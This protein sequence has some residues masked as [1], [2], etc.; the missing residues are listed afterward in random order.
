MRKGLRG[1]LVMGAAAAISLGVSSFDAEAASIA[2]AKVKVNYNTQQLQITGTTDTKFYLATSTVSINKKTD[3]VT[4]KTAAATEYDASAVGTVNIDLSSYV[5][6]K[7]NYVSVWGNKNEEPILIKL[8]AAT[9]KMKATV[10]AVTSTVRIDNTADSKNPVDITNSVEYCTVNGSWADYYNTTTKK[11]ADL[12]GCSKLG[13][14]IRFRVKATAAAA[15]LPTATTNI[16]NDKDGKAVAAFVAPGN[17]AS[18]E[19]KAKIA[20]TAAGPKATFDYNLRTIKIPATS[21]YRSVL[22]TNAV[23]LKNEFTASGV[24]KGTAIISADTLLAKGAV[25]FDLRTAA[26]ATKPASKITEYKLPAI[27]SIIAVA[28]NGKAPTATTTVDNAAVGPTLN[29][30]GYNSPHVKFNALVYNAKTKVVTGIKLENLLTGTTDKY[31]VV[32]SDDNT[33]PAANAKAIT[34]N[35]GNAKTGASKITQVAAKEG[36][37]VFIRKMGDVKTTV[38]ATP[39]VLLGKV[40]AAPADDATK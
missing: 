11:F 20:K 10:N 5:V 31:Q 3:V 9:T 33:V 6:T 39:Y 18:N 21:E 28:S 14:T 40:P 24:D 36:K 2:P 27:G 26:T 25:D 4:L 19:V 1:L 34:L 32:V 29:A 23:V 12:T 17:F 8:P 22:S 35:P 15:A 7:D 13:A 37:F 16:G 38:W 30:A